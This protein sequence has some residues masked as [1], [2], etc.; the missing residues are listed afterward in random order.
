MIP[1]ND[2]VG[3]LTSKEFFIFKFSVNYNEL[4][5]LREAS[6]CVEHRVHEFLASELR[7]NERKFIMFSFENKMNPKKINTLPQ[8]EI[9]KRT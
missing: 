2:S 7:P 5:N 1:A 8:E 3:V 6:K 9:K 4:R